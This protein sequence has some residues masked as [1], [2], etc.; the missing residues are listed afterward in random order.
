MSTN[1][2]FRIAVH[3]VMMRHHEG[4]REVLLG[5]RINTSY[6]DGLYSF[7]AGHVE[8]FEPPHIALQRET[9]EE[10]GVVPAFKQLA[11]RQPALITQ[12]LKDYGPTAAAQ[13]RF[14]HYTEYFFRV[15][16]WEGQLHNAEPDKCADLRFF[17]LNALPR[18]MLP[19]TTHALDQ[20][21]KRNAGVSDFGWDNP[22]FPHWKQR[23]GLGG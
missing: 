5:Q 18:N 23:W 12:H 10:L 19:L 14:R 17:P 2:S 7:P 15:P 21:E 1:H 11:D 4:Q 3:A 20:M 22:D 9:R 8:M 13:N 16:E 6:G